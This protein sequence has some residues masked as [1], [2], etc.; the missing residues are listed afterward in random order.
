M[1]EA[2]DG[3]DQVVL[4]ANLTNFSHFLLVLAQDEKHAVLNLGVHSL[5]E[6]GAQLGFLG[7]FFQE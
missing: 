4:G 1:K 5:L 6:A 2:F 7:D 3:V